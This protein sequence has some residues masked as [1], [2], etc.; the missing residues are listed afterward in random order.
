MRANRSLSSMVGVFFLFLIFGGIS[1]GAADVPALKNAP[2]PT[3]RARVAKLIEAA[4]AEGDLI[5]DG[6]MI[7]PKMMQYVLKGFKETYGLPDLKT[8][9]TYEGTSRIVTRVSQVLRAGRPGPDIVWN[10]SWAWYMD[11]LAHKQIMRYDCPWYKDY[12]IS[13]KVGN[14]MPGYWVS[15]SYTFLPMWNVTA[16][17]KAGIKNFRPTSWWDFTDP[18]LGKLSS[19]GNMSRS[20]SQTS[21]G[22]GLRKV[23]G[24]EWFKKMAKLKPA[25]F[26]RGAGGRDWCASGEYPIDV[27]GSAKNTFVLQTGGL[28]VKLLYPK[29]GVVLLPLAPIILTSARHP[30]VAKLFIDYVRSVPGTNRVSGSGAGLIMGR[31]GVKN[32]NKE[33]FPPAET[34]NLIP[35]DWNKESTLETV[36][37]FQ[38]WVVDIGLSY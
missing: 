6:T 2:D 18:K 28:N 14:S 16:L 9:Y 7:E 29:E 38:K 24:D 17:E 19:I 21:V 8:Q 13:H 37:A 30:N 27:Y 32:P 26:T 4:R 25:L 35:M 12:T 11:L 20:Q 15:D 36:K 5:I 10:V 23:L 33:L 31:P 22:M 1:Y 3:E 34:I